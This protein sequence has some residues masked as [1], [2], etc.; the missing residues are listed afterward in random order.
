MLT[1][2]YSFEYVTETVANTIA[3]FNSLN[4]PVD[5]IWILKYLSV[6]MT[7]TAAWSIEYYNGT[8]SIPLF[9]TALL[10]GTD[11]KIYNPFSDASTTTLLGR[12]SHLKIKMKQN[13]Y[14]QIRRGSTVGGATI[15]ALVEKWG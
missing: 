14:L 7:N 13:Q 1:D 8:V 6:T 5:K 11:V 2:K 12:E 15:K 9:T 3:V 4:P 10:S